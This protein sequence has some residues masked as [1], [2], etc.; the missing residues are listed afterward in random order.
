[1]QIFELHF[2]PKL[3]EEEIFDSFVFQPEN[4]YEKK[5]GSLYMVGELQN[6]LPQNLKFL[7]K[8]AGV[9][10]KNYYTLSAKSPEKAL[11]N[12]LKKINEYL[13][14]EIKKDNVSW[15]GNLNFAV[16]SLSNSSLTFTKSGELKILLLRKGQ[17]IDIGK[18]LDLREIEPYPIKI[19]LNIAS[20]KLIENDAILV[21]TKD[22]FEFFQQQ[23]LLVKLAQSENVDS[24]KIKEILPPHLFQKGGGAKVSGI[25]FLAVV[26]PE[27]KKINPA[28][29]FKKIVR[30]NKIDKKWCGVKIKILS[31]IKLSKIKFPKI[32]LPHLKIPIKKSGTI[33]EKFQLKKNAKK[34]LVL[35]FTLIAVLIFG[36]FIFKEAGEKKEKAIKKSLT[37]IED[38]EKLNKLEKI[39][40]PEIVPSPDPNLFFSFSSSLIKPPLF[41][42]NFDLSA[43]YL[44]NLYFLEKKTCRIIK[45]LYLGTENWAEP[46]IWKGADEHCAEPKAMVVDG[47]IWLLNSDNSLVRYYGGSWQETLK[48]DFFPSPENITK[49]ETK[50]NLPYLYLLEPVN[51]RVIIIDKTGAIVRQFQSEKFDNLKNLAISEDGKTIY[52]LNDSEVYKIEI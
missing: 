9:I 50:K 32:K 14:Q 44:H 4:V 30:A 51:K 20:G 7:D 47:S 39:E 2:N 19:F 29:F 37:E 46:T 12:C 21:L 1:M 22:V 26:K 31:K 49:I 35:I 52:L 28:P 43:S 41:E 27:D 16:L 48:P 36:F 42:F 3:K 6:T 33:I 17:L 15:L 40:N 11:S 5:L 18:E 38:L 24:K 45:Y 34:K 23:N 13:D 8:V 10:K 25:C